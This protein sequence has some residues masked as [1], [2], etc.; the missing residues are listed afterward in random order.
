MREWMR[1][2]L[3]SSRDGLVLVDLD[4]A[5]RRYG[6]R[7]GLDADGDLLLLE[8]KE[9]VGQVTGGEMRV[10]GWLDKAIKASQAFVERWRGWNV[11]RIVYKSQPC[12]CEKCNQ[13]IENADQAYER[14]TQATLYLGSKKI[15]HADLR[16]WLEKT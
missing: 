9:Y 1:R 8:K 7:Y 10:Y 2:E 3:P 12:I 11:L 13:P 14:F 15:S 6:Q 4:L 16:E 5:I